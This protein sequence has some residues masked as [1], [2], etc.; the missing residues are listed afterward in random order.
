MMDELLYIDHEFVRV[1]RI[2][3]RIQN[4][5]FDG[6]TF[7][8]CDFSQTE[9]RDCSF[10]GCNFHD[11]SFSMTKM[12]ATSLKN[13]IFFKC[14]LLGIRFDA[15]DDF[16]FEV[17][18]SGCTL[19]YSWFSGKKMPKTSFVD[20]SLKGVNFSQT[21]LSNAIFSNVDL[22]DAVFDDTKLDGADFTQALNYRIDPDHNSLKKARFGSDGVH[23][24]LEK[25]QIIIK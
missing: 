5:E 12:P 14:K 15:C 21:D 17:E 10:I 16:L 19:D 7:R 24:L 11:C 4:R 1:I 22:A 25:Y 6:C 13:A 23:G 3:E 2:D 20:S 18:F 8:N 9:F